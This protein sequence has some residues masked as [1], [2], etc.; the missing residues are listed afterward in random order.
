MKKR[1]LKKLL[2]DKYDNGKNCDKRVVTRVKIL[3]RHYFAH[4][5]NL[6]EAFVVERIPNKCKP[7]DMDKELIRLIGVKNQPKN[8]TYRVS[9]HYFECIK[10]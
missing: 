4:W 5:D 7:S 6:G 1:L 2:S 3:A 8:L 10:K 9:R